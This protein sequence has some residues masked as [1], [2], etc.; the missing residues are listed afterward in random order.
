MFKSTLFTLFAVMLFSSINAQSIRFTQSMYVEY[1]PEYSE[2]DEW[3]SDW[4]DLGEDTR[5]TMYISEVV[6]GKVYNVILYLN[7]EE[8]SNMNVRYDAEQSEKIR[9]DWDDPY[10]NCYYDDNG[11]YIYAQKVSLEQLSKDSTPWQ[12]EE[13]QMYLWVLSENYG[14]ALR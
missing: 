12:N 11:D 8:S 13:S 14:I 2:W 9:K 4:T 3:P 10:V 1:H 6:R 5:I 7:G